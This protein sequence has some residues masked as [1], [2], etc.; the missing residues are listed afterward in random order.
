M[1]LGEM[2]APPLSFGWSHTGL[3]LDGKRD[4]VGGWMGGG[5]FVRV[6]E[7]G[8][9]GRGAFELGGG[10]MADSVSALTEGEGATD[11]GR[12]HSA[13]AIPGPE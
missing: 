11:A 3:L 6:E 1:I 12:L 2:A 7:E 9:G 5:G 10:R 8:E 4:T 13:T